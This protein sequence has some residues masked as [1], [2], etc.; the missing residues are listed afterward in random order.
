MLVN[1]EEEVLLGNDFLVGA[2]GQ[3]LS[4][5]LVLELHKTDLLLHDLVDPFANLLEVIRASSFTQGLVGAWHG[6]I[7]FQGV[8][9]GSL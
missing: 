3:I 7:L 6:R 9:I 5:D 8:K 4:L 1:L 2:L